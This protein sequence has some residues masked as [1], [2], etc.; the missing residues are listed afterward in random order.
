MTP[1]AGG[2]GYHYD[3][4]GRLLAETDAGG[5]TRAEYL[6]LGNEPLALSRSGQLYYYHNDHLGTPQKL[7]DGA[8]QVV[9]SASYRPFGEASIRAGYV[10]QNLRFPGQYYDEE[11]GLH[12]NYQRY[13]DPGTG[14]YLT[15]D[16]IGLQGG[17]NTYTYVENNPLKHIDP[18]GLSKFDKFFG[19]PKQFWNWFHRHPDM[20]N[21]KGPDGQVSKDIA[22][23]YYKEWR[24]LGKPKPDNKGKQKGFA[25]PDLLEWLIPWPLIPSELG[26]GELD[27]NHNGIPDYEEENQC[28]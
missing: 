1:K 7:T 9:W 5:R 25:D 21:L 2:S 26:C 10:T 12:Y 14:R 11:S 3:L 17:L 20:K 4:A 24:D 28:K 8:G 19:L 16:P 18:Y 15:S 27:C 23:D 22:D 13:Y 6:Y